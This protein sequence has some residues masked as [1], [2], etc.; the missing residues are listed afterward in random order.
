MEEEASPEFRLRKLDESR[1]YI[2]DETNND[3]T[4]ENF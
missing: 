2:L 1:N 3:L 4:S